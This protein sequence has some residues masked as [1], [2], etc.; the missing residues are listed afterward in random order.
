MILSFIIGY[1]DVLSHCSLPSSPLFRLGYLTDIV[2]SF[3]RPLIFHNTL[4]DRQVGFQPR[5]AFSYL[6]RFFFG[7]FVF[8]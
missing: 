6:S 2:H 5:F 4:M 3:V 8:S 7:L 1:L